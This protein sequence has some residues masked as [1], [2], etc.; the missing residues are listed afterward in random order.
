MRPPSGSQPVQQSQ[1]MQPCITT[2]AFSLHRHNEAKKAS[3][4]VVLN[5]LD[6]ARITAPCPQSASKPIRQEGQLSET[7][8]V[9]RE[10]MCLCRPSIF[11]G[12]SHGEAP[13]LDLC[14]F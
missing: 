6:S 4:L 1:R 10:L 2:T 5:L 3:R 7:K 14:L 12:G 13:M 9:L 11:E 8:T